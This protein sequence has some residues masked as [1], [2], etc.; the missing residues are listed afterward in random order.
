MFVLAGARLQ[1]PRALEDVPE[2]DTN[3]SSA[4][5][6]TVK[7]KPSNISVKTH[8]PKVVSNKVLGKSGKKA[9]S[10]N[11]KIRNYNVKDDSV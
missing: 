4:E 5:S 6:F 9:A 8:K 3:P 10:K 7:G 11:N 1:T 2:L